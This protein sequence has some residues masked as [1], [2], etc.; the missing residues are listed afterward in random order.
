M[1]TEPGDAAVAAAS[2]FLIGTISGA[3][4][5]RGHPAFSVRNNVPADVGANIRRHLVTA[6]REPTGTVW[7]DRS[8][9][10]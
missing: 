6:S 1:N 5:R 9:G 10:R 4:S 3:V 7:S 2:I 8:E